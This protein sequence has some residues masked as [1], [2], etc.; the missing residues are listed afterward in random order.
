LLQWR[1]FD[2]EKPTV[3]D[4]IIQAIHNVIEVSQL[5]ER[6]FYGSFFRS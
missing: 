3:F 5:C 1:S 4:K 2:A 6:Y